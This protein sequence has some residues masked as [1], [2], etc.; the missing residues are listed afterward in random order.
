MPVIT[1]IEDL[2]QLAWKKLPRVLFEYID[3]GA[4]DEKTLRAN[5]EDFGRWQLAQ[6]VLRAAD[7]EKSRMLLERLNA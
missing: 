1:S 4:Q 6:R 3:G 2:R 7:A 5:Q